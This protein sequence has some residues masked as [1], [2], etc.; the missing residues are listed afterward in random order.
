MAIL[1]ARPQMPV[2]RL[3]DLAVVLTALE[4]KKRFVI[5]MDMSW[6]A[7]KAIWIQIAPAMPYV[8]R[9]NKVAKRVHI[10]VALT[11]MTMRRMS[12]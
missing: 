3:A 4:L 6:T 7:A 8:Q 10:I 2:V 11:V 9:G 12:F 5:F 1:A